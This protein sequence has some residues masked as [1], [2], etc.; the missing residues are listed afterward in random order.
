VPLA[1]EAGF[2][3]GVEVENAGVLDFGFV[4]VTESVISVAFSP[5]GRTALSG[6]VD[7]TLTLWDIATGHQLRM[8][9]GHAAAV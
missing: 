6:N 5:D 8:F 1:L 3:F 2:A 9:S 4:G 7:G